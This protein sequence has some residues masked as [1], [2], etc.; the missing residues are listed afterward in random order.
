MVVV[1]RVLPVPPAD[2]PDVDVGIAVK[3]LVL[4]L[5]GVVTDELLPVARLA[6]DLADKTQERRPVE[7]APRREALDKPGREVGHTRSRVGFS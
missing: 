3:L 6:T 5:L 7:I 2:Q 1:P 4:P